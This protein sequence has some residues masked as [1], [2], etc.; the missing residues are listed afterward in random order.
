MVVRCYLHKISAHT[1]DPERERKREREGGRE[2]E[3]E[4][5]REREKE[6]GGG[7]KCVGDSLITASHVLTNHCGRRQQDLPVVAS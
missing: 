3:R 2:R 1:A 6:G 5:E 7:G 4:G